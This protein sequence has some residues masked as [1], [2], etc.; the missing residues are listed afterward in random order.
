NADI[1]EIILTGEQEGWS[2]VGTVLELLHYSILASIIAIFLFSIKLLSASSRHPF[3]L[4]R[5]ALST[6]FLLPL[7]MIVSLILNAHFFW[8]FLY[9]LA[10]IFGDGTSERPVMGFWSHLFFMIPY[11]CLAYFFYRANKDDRTA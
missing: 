1:I 5:I 8:Q 3:P 7:Y 10:L 6:M 2:F 11:F 9:F 4:K